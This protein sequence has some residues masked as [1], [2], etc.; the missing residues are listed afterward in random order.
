MGIFSPAIQAI[1]EKGK[2]A[3]NIGFENKFSY[4]LKQE[5]DRFVRLNKE[6]V[7][8]FFDAQSNSASQKKQVTQ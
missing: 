1:R 6:I 4:H 8:Q 3:E 2:S 7:K 5:S